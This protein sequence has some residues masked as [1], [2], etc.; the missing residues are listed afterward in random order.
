MAIIEVANV[1]KQF[2]KR[3]EKGGNKEKFY[4][5]KDVSLKIEEGEIF[6]ILG[7][8]GAG[9][10]TL[11]NIV[12]GIVYHDVGSVKVFSGDVKRGEVVRSIGYVSGEE[13]F[14]WALT[15]FDVLTFGGLLYGLGGKERKERTAELLRVFG[16]EGVASSKFD[17]LS[18]GEKMR[19]AFA[20]ALIN[21]PKLL[22]LD[23]PTLGLDP[24]TAIKVRKEIRRI[25][26]ELGTTIV[27]TSHY[28]REVEQLCGRVAFINK[29]RIMHVGKVSDIRKKHQNLE[30][31]FVEMTKA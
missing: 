2:G 12:M 17:V 3:R 31:Y 15:P 26:R 25:N 24:D 1:S 22:L 28:M 6:G 5:L 30:T 29:G 13:R 19:L 23:E 11:L 10:T 20:Y 16:L 4:A 27:L 8:N 7:P 18:T 14:H 21:K 9:K